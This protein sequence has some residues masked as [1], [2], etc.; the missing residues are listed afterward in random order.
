ML[1]R[2]AP[3]CEQCLRLLF[4]PSVFIPISKKYLCDLNKG[5]YILNGIQ[6][7]VRNDQRLGIDGGS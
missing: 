5:A 4:H 3:I 7:H 2:S 1:S 6:R